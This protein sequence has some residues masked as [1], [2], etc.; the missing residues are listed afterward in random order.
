MVLDEWG[1]RTVGQHGE[2]A[3]VGWVGSE[4]CKGDKEVSWRLSTSL[5][6]IL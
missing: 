5:P 1:E 3:E 2:R 4:N 6:P